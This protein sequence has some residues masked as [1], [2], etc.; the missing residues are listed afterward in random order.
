M[1][2]VQML[3]VAES[4]AASVSGTLKCNTVATLTGQQIMDQAQFPLPW[5]AYGGISSTPE[6]WAFS[7]Y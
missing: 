6:A 1:W 2:P 3:A 5:M 7:Q 4:L